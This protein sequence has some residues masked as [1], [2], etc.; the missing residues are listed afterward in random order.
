[1]A[2]IVFCF[3]V[4]QPRRLKWFWPDSVRNEKVENMEKF[5][6]D[7]DENRK[8]FEKVAKK[9]YWPTNKILLGLADKFKNQNKKF[10]I[11]FSITGTW[12][13]QCEKYEPVLIDTFKQMAESGCV[14]FLDETYYHSLAGLF[15][16]KS[17]FREEVIEHRKAMKE[18][19]NFSPKVFRNTELLYNN[20]IAKEVENLGYKG[21]FTEGIERILNGRSPNFIYRAKSE[22]SD[23]S[24]LVVL[25]KNYKLSDDIAFRF[26]WRSW[27]EFPLTAD[28]YAKWLSGC[29]GDVINLYMDYET[30]GEHQWA[31]TGIFE[32]L[33]FLP[34][35]ILK[36]ENLDF[37][38]PYEAIERYKNTDVGEGNLI[39]VPWDKTISWADTE[40]DH[41]AWLGNHNQ[42]LCFSEV[43]RIAYLIEK[44]SDEAA[45]IK[46]KKIWRY[47][48]TSDH[49]HYMSTKNIAD[50]EIHNYFS[51][52]TN[53][54]DAAVNLMSIISDLKE[55]ILIQLI[56]EAKHNE[57]RMKQEKEIMKQEKEIL[58][59]EQRKEAYEG[60]RIFKM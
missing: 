51:N 27:N 12:L 21:I 28:K 32:F 30:F 49:Y 37:L 36:H 22:K 2:S 8:I 57:E 19:L 14:E 16:D 45:K 41:S 44:I 35:E 56:N 17:E 4:H 5:Y 25:L 23:K 33:K 39:D 42:Q 20:E 46:F 55:K 48:L 6:Y 52:R 1:M 60:N 3:E 9:C 10:K 47:L 13:E 40:R 24:N 54:Y 26:S 53:A 58:E 43:Q 34:D 15:A 59:A 29:Q 7:D 31:E 38:T 18:I 11:A 50:Q